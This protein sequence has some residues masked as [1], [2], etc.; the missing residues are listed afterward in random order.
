MTPLPLPPPTRARPTLR[1]PFDRE[2]KNQ[3][4][5]PRQ[6]EERRVRTRF[7][8][9]LIELVRNSVGTAQR[10]LDLVGLI[11]QLLHL[12]LHILLGQ[13]EVRWGSLKTLP[14]SFRYGHC[15]HLDLA[16]VDLAVL[17][18]QVLVRLRHG[19]KRHHGIAQVLRRE[20]GAL[21][22]EG[23][24]RELGELRLVHALL[25]EG[26]QGPLL[27]RVLT[28]HG[29]QAIHTETDV[30]T[31]SLREE[32]KDE[33]GRRHNLAGSVAQLAH[34]LLVPHELSI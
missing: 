23:L 26:A 29:I 6:R 25:L 5:Y 2:S 31:V 18:A 27:D 14:E 11:Q 21:D 17:L 20:R 15:A 33:T 1:F 19:V 22:V 7:E 13:S 9:C 16:N 24:L 10:L 32:E 8:F 28:I 34:L 12:K 30:I 4:T 3:F